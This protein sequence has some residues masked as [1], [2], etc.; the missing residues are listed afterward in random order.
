VALDGSDS[1]DPDDDP[2]TWSWLQ[3]AG[4]PVVLNLTDPA[5]P[6]FTAPLVGP[7]GETLTFVLTVSDT[8]L[9]DQDEVSVFVENVNH[10]PTADAGA[11]QT[12]NEGAAVALDGSAS[13]DPDGDAL[14]WTWLQIGGPVVSLSDTG[15]AAPT[16]TAP[17]VGFGGNTLVFR[18]TVEDGLGGVDTDEVSIQVLDTNAAPVCDLARPSVGELW[19]PNHKMVAV[20]ILGVT[21]P[22]N[23]GITIT[24][25]GVTQDEPTGGLGDGDTSP[26][27]V[28]QGGTVLLR[29]ERSGNGN[30]RVYRVSYRASDGVNSCTGQVTVT[31]PHSK[32]RNAPS[33]VDD[34][35]VYNSLLP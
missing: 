11:D 15:S 6:T 16:F 2:I 34:G 23:D 3:T 7:L 33:A 9:E 4:P 27:A 8:E 12:R 14:T 31:V 25:L 17:Q 22:E 26:D 1:F 13:Q 35:Q 32:G 10:D 21:D 28:I 20:S 24:V 5:R 29:A 18:L 30:G 19:P